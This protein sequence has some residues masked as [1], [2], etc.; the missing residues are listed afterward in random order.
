MPEGMVQARARV[1]VH[2]RLARDHHLM[3]LKAPRVAQHALPG[4]FIHLLCQ[5]PA[6]VCSGEATYPFLRRPFSLLN[7]DPRLGTVEFIYKVVGL[8]TKALT[9]LPQGGWVDLLGPLGRPF[10]I[11]EGLERAILVGGGVGIPPLYFLAKRLVEGARGKGRGAGESRKVQAEVFLG[12][13]TQEWVI[14]REMFRKLSLKVHI[15]TDDGTLGHKGAVV[16]LLKKGFPRPPSPAPRPMLFICGPTPMMRA[17]A[18][19]ARRRRLPAQVSLEERMGCAM[20]C[21][22]GCVV[23]VATE[24][25]D[26]HARFQRVC[27]EGPVFEAQEVLWKLAVC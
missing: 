2:R 19:L 22:W 4:Q 18:A 8:G 9:Q 10:E 17:A 12:A 21:C 1:L 14:C 26:A 13:R 3:R 6:A 16:D 23:E 15:A 27:T 5:E 24:P 20:G 25:P 11:P 7:A